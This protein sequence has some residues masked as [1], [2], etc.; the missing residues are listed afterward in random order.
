MSSFWPL[1]LY[2]NILMEVELQGPLDPQKPED[3]SLKQSRVISKD[4]S[5]GFS[6]DLRFPFPL[7][8]RLSIKSSPRIIFESLYRNE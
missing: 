8:F 5:L 4:E 7:T 3:R 1:L 6:V 2:A